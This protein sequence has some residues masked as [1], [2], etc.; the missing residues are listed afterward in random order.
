MRLTKQEWYRCHKYALQQ[1]PYKVPYS[2]AFDTKAAEIENAK[3][4]NRRLSR[5]FADPYRVGD[6]DD[7]PPW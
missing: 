4:L 1:D 2:A 3:P 7:N 5:E 6:D